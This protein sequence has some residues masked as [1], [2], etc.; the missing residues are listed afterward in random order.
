MLRNKV[1]NFSS[2]IILFI[3]FLTFNDFLIGKDHYDNKKLIKAWNDFLNY[4]SEKNLELIYNR[5]SIKKGNKD[6]LFNSRLS[7][8]FKKKIMNDFR[9]FSKEVYSSNREAVRVMFILTKCKL[10]IGLK[11]EVKFVLSSLIIINPKMF[12][13]EFE[14]YIRSLNL[15]KT[16]ELKNILLYFSP[17]YMKNKNAMLCEATRRLI[18]LERVKQKSLERIK[19]KCIQLLMEKV[20]KNKFIN[21]N[22]FCDNIIFNEISDNLKTI[23]SRVYYNSM[24]DY[25]LMRK[26]VCSCNRWMIKD[27]F[28]LYYNDLI[29][30]II[31]I[32]PKV[33]LKEL[34]Y[35]INN[36]NKKNYILEEFVASTGPDYT[37][38]FEAQLLENS[39]KI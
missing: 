28:N 23:E 34:Q 24:N 32:N 13:E 38:K 14:Y 19:K 30:N 1:Y 16:I 25:K 26:E 6:K 9:F 22:D 20:I 8:E 7:K 2:L 17:F 3:L 37:E 4:P 15:N 29:G 10:Q 39:K 31:R 5:I 36:S 33:F 12:L 11:N 18:S 27:C 21:N 35:F